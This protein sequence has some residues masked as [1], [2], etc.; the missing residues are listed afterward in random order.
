MNIEKTDNTIPFAT[1]SFFSNGTH[2]IRIIYR[3]DSVRATEDIDKK[4]KT[5]KVFPVWFSPDFPPLDYI[6]RT[7]HNTCS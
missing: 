7:M 5:K 1:I 3:T 6:K 2:Y 4:K